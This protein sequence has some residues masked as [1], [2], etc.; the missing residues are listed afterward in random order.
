VVGLGLTALLYMMYGFTYCG[1]AHYPRANENAAVAMLRNVAA[2]QEQLRSRGVLDRDGDGVG[3]YGFFRD[4]VADRGDDSSPLLSK[5]YT[6]HLLGTG[7][8]AVLRSAYCFRIFLPGAEGLGVP[9]QGVRSLSVAPDLAEKSWSAYAWPSV[10]DDSGSRAFFIDERGGV[11]A[12]PV[13]EG[14]YRGAS[15]GPAW[16]AALPAAAEDTAP[17]SSTF[18]GR[19]GRTWERLDWASGS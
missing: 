18:V 1:C 10:C 6:P 8:S 12:T 17:P 14:P 11:F 19:D 9:E 3:E 2:A 15:A 7:E 5:S 13:E 4:L 16:D